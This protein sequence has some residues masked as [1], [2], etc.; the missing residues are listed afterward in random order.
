MQITIITIQVTNFFFTGFNK[1][2]ELN[3]KIAP[4]NLKRPIVRFVKNVQER[5]HKIN[6]LQQPEHD[7]VK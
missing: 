4:I 3:M 2:K 6:P 5:L 1:H 7:T